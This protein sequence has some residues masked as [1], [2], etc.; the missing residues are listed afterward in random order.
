M[1]K[2][3]SDSNLRADIAELSCRPPE[4][5]ILFAKRLVNVA[6]VGGRLLTLSGHIGIRDFRDRSKE[7]DDSKKEDEACN[8]EVNPLDGL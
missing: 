5:G 7:E 3:S 6:G 8:S 1:D 4:Q 2:I